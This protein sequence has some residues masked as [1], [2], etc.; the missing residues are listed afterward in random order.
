MP[1]KSSAL[2]FVVDYTNV[3]LYVDKQT[4]SFSLSNKIMRFTTSGTTH[5]RVID[6]F[7]D[8]SNHLYTRI[9]KV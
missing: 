5:I 1:K 2:Y 3:S 7:K 8:I 6:L 4:N 9:A